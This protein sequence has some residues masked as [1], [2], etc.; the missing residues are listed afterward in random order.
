MTE[1]GPPGI[2]PGWGNSIETALVGARKFESLGQRDDAALAALGTAA[3]IH[4]S[5]G[6]DRIER[7]V[8]YLAQRL[9]AGISDLGL[10]QVTPSDPDLS[11]GVCITQAPAG[12]GGVISN[13]LYEEFGITGA[14]TG[15]LRLSPTIYNTEEH[16]DRAVAGMK[17]LMT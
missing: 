3:E 7:R 15:G 10:Q 6:P 11:F 12:Q 1:S 14:A 16:L 4:D 5:I 17:V 8:V 9:K 13:R 2:A